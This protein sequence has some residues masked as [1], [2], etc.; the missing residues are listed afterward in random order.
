MIYGD[1]S[2]EPC[3]RSCPLVTCHVWRFVVLTPLLPDGIRTSP[4]SFTY[5]MGVKSGKRRALMAYSHCSPQIP[6][7]LTTMAAA[8]LAPVDL[9]KYRIILSFRASLSAGENS[10]SRHN[11]LL[12]LIFLL[13]VTAE[14]GRSLQRRR[15][16]SSLPAW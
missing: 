10:Q 8:K 13:A 16:G 7:C 2:F 14:E 15:R 1:G 4:A 5:A 6:L 9:W 12:A 3:V 11:M